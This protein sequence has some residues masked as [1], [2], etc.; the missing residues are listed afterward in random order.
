MQQIDEILQVIPPESLRS[1]SLDGVVSMIVES[2]M[3]LLVDH[4]YDKNRNTTPTLSLFGESAAKA[5]EELET[6]IITPLC[7]HEGL[8]D[9]LYGG[10]AME[11]IRKGKIICAGALLTGPPGSGLSTMARHCA[12][13]AASVVPSMKLLIVG[14]TSLV[15]KEVGGSEQAIHKLFVAARNAAP[16]IL[17]LDGLENIARVRGNDS[18]TYGTLDRILSVL[19]TEIDGVSINDEGDGGI[20]DARI[21]V[22]GI[23]HNASWIDPALRRPNRLDKCITLEYP[24]LKARKCIAMHQLRDL[25]IDFSI[26]TYFEPKTAG[27]LADWIALRTPGMSATEVI[28]ICTEAVMTCLREQ[29]DQQNCS[30]SNDSRTESS[31]N[32]QKGILRYQ[33]FASA[34]HFRSTG[35]IS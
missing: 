28:A 5:W 1:G 26:A 17:V 14:C 6:L 31:N 4:G 20:A 33:H 25:P 35:T 12:S 30:G 24:D 11:K 7:R 18:T 2:S 32:N 29:V 13:V 10:G 9:L 16:C 27:E 22:I 23:T 3:E 21:A 15:H 34:L 19:L 8:D